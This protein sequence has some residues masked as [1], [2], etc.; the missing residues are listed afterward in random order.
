LPWLDQPD[1][2]AAGLQQL[3]QR[4]PVDAS[5]FHG[6]RGDAAL[7]QPVG[8]GKQV[9]GIGPEAANVAGQTTV[10]AGRRWPDA[11]GWDA[12]HVH[13]RMHV[14]A[15]GVGV[16]DGQGRRSFAWWPRGPGLD[17]GRIART[18]AL[19]HGVGYLGTVGSGQ[20][21]WAKRGKRN[22]V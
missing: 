1:L 12:G 6:H 22:A 21:A 5:R 2:K 3:V 8:D 20:P 15:G 13:I 16:E 17:F 10:R 14:N 19:A 11:R 4:D 7:L 18:L 9:A